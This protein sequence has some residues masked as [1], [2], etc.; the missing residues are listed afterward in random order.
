[1]GG[2]GPRQGLGT[3]PVTGPLERPSQRAPEN[4]KADPER[5][6]RQRRQVG[7]S[8]ALLAI[9]AAEMTLLVASQRAARKNA[10]DYIDAALGARHSASIA[11]VV[12]RFASQRTTLDTLDT[13]ARAAAMRRMASDEANE[14]ANLALVHAAEKRALKHN[15]ALAVLPAQQAARRALRQ[16]AR[17]HR[18]VMA[19]AVSTRAMSLSARDP[20]VLPRARSNYFIPRR[21]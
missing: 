7:A 10:L 17:R 8:A 15:A 21:R 6:Y 18:I 5:R 9:S 16:S 20:L 3:G 11:A 14:L 19:I 12:S 13:G 4:R 1:M 2:S